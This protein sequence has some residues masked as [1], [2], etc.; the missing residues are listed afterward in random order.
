MAVAGAVSNACGATDVAD[1]VVVAAN[2]APVPVT[3][4]ANV[5]TVKALIKANAFQGID[6]RFHTPAFESA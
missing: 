6:A 5:K 1:G 2:P 4:V 3:R